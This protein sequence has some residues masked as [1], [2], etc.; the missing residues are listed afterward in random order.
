MHEYEVCEVLCCPLLLLLAI[1]YPYIE[2]SVVLNEHL[3]TAKFLA[4][5]QALGAVIYF[6]NE[7]RYRTSVLMLVCI[8][9]S[10][11]F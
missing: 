10:L 11:I 7:F 4:S 3:D 9:L 1:C 5:G 8:T 2:S 6:W